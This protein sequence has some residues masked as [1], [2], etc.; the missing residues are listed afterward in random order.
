[1]KRGSVYLFLPGR[2]RKLPLKGRDGEKQPRYS[3]REPLFPF[4][5][6]AKGGKEKKRKK[7]KS[8][9]KQS[10]W[11]KIPFGYFFPPRSPEG[12]KRG[13]TNLRAGLARGER[14]NGKA[15]ILAE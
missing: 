10:L 8:F 7:E 11:G 2:K 12:G 13:K 4:L 9:K 6:T 3:T 1:L 15:L 14:K 5:W